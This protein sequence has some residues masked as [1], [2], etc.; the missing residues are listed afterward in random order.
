MKKRFVLSRFSKAVALGSTVLLAS[1]PLLAQVIS[2]GRTQTQIHTSGATTNVTTQSISQGHGVNSFSQFDVGQG[3]TVNLHAPQ[4]TQG[5]VNIVSGSQSQIHGMVRGMQNGQ[6]GGNVYIANPNG[7]V[8]GPSGTIRGGSV[9][10]STPSQSALNGM[11][12]STGGINGQAMQRV[13]DGSAPLGPGNITVRGQVLA[14]QHLGL[15]AGGY[16]EIDGDLVAG[17]DLYRGQIHVDGHRGVRITGNGR[18]NSRHGQGGGSVR[19][20]SGQN[21]TVARGARVLSQSSGSADAG[22]IYLFAEDSALLQPGAVISAV[23]TGD[24]AGGIVEFSARNTVEAL[25]DLEAWSAA[26]QGGEIIIDPTDLVLTSQNTLGADL[27]LIASGSI[28][29]SAGEVVTTQGGDVTLTAPR[30][31]LEQ[32]SVI[33]ASVLSGTGGNIHIEARLDDRLTDNATAPGDV[34]GNALPFGQAE[35]SI[36]GAILRGDAVFVTATVYKDNV[37]QA[38][39][40]VESL[41]NELKGTLGDY[42]PISDILELAIT[43]G[44][45]LQAALDD[46]DIENLPSYLDARTRITID[47]S[48]IVADKLVEVVASSTTHF[49]IAPDNLNLALAIAGS[50]TQADVL[51]HNSAIDAEAAISIRSEVNEQQMLQARS[52][53]QK[54][55]AEARAFN[56]ALAASLRRSRARTIV[57]GVRPLRAYDENADTSSNSLYVPWNPNVDQDEYAILTS[58]GP[59]EIASD[60]IKDLTL[61]SEALVSSDAK[62][63]ALTVSIEDSRAETRF[64]GVMAS[65]SGHVDV[66]AETVYDTY[67]TRSR[68]SG[69]SEAVTN[70]NTD[71]EDQA[72]SQEDQQGLQADSVNAALAFMSG[73]GVADTLALPGLSDG[74]DSG[75]DDEE[76]GRFAFAGTL[77]S[78]RAENIAALGGDT[79]YEAPDGTTAQFYAPWIKTVPDGSYGRHG[80]TFYADG[81]RVDLDMDP[82]VT[83]L[84]RNRFKDLRVETLAQV[85]SVPAETPEGDP[86][87]TGD[88]TGETE[89]QLDQAGDRVLM[90]TAGITHWDLSAEAT[91]DG[92][93]VV[94]H[95]AWLRVPSDVQVLSENSFAKTEGRDDVDTWWEA[96]RAALEVRESD[97]P[98]DLIE[99]PANDDTP[100]DTPADPDEE[101]GKGKFGG[102]LGGKLGGVGTGTK[103]SLT[104]EEETP[105]DPAADPTVVTP[106][107]LPS[108]TG[109]DD[110]PVPET[111][112]DADE[113]PATNPT[114]TRMFVAQSTG[115]GSEIGAGVNLLSTQIGLE[116]KTTVQNTRIEQEGYYRLNPGLGPID[117]EAKLSIIARNSGDIL[118]QS[119]L[120]GNSTGGEKGGYGGALS[121]T[122]VTARAQTQINPNTVL[123]LPTT[124]I[125]SEQDLL[126]GN[127]ARAHG[128]NDSS[129]TA[130]N[131]AVGITRYDAQTDVALDQA[132]LEG[133]EAVEI[134]ARDAS[135]VVTLAGSGAL[136]AETSLAIGVAVNLTKRDSSLALDGAELNVGDAITLLAETSGEVLAAGTASSRDERPPEPEPETDETAPDADPA[137]PPTDPAD[138]AEAEQETPITETNDGAVDIA[139]SLFGDQADAV[140]QSMG[141]G[142]DGS[143]PDTPAGGGGSGE[144]DSRTFSFA[145]DFAGTFGTVTTELLLTDSE[146]QTDLE[147][148][149][150]AIALSDIH[151]GQAGSVTASA[152]DGVGITGSFGLSL[153]DHMTQTRLTDTNIYL[154]ED[155]LAEGT[156]TEIAARDR[157]VFDVIVTGRAGHA[158]DAWGLAAAASFN[159]FDST[160]DLELLRSNITNGVIYDFGG[161]GE[162][163]DLGGD[164]PG[165]GELLDPGLGDE[166]GDP[167]DEGP[168]CIDAVC[169]ENTVGRS[170]ILEAEAAPT[171]TVTVFAAR[172]VQGAEAQ[173][174]QQMEKV[175]DQFEQA[176]LQA[177][178]PKEDDQDPAAPPSSEPADDEDRGKGRKGVS[179]AI[180][181]SVVNAKAQVSLR[182][183]YVL[184]DRSAAKLGVSDDETAGSI[185]V[186]SRAVSTANV[187]ATSGTVGL[188]FVLTDTRSQIEIDDTALIAGGNGAVTVTSTVAENQTV[189]ARVASDSRYKVAGILSLR[190]AQNHVI[191]DGDGMGGS[192]IEGGDNTAVTAQTTRALAFEA[193]ASD[194]T[195][196]TLAGAGIVS[197]GSADTAVLMGGTAETEKGEITLSALDTTT[198]YSARAI[199]TTGPLTDAE[200]DETI[201]EETA[202][203]EE[204]GTGETVKKPK[205]PFGKPAKAKTPGKDEDSGADNNGLTT[206]FA[207][208]A[209]SSQERAEGEAETPAPDA[210]DSA[211]EEKASSAPSFVIAIN[212][213]RSDLSAQAQVGGTYDDAATGDQHDLS[214]AALRGG[215]ATVS[216]GVDL[217]SYSKETATKAGSI[218]GTSLGF[219]GTVSYG[220]MQHAAKALLGQ[221]DAPLAI[222]TLDLSAQNTLPQNDLSTLETALGGMHDS[223]DALGEEDALSAQALLP[224][225]SVDLERDRWNIINRTEGEAKQSFV[226]DLGIHTANLETIAEVQDGGTLPGG[227]LNLSARNSGGLTALRDIPLDKAKAPEPTEAEDTDTPSDTPDTPADG[228]ADADAQTAGDDL[229]KEDRKQARAEAETEH[230]SFGLGAAVQYLKID[231]A[232]RAQIGQV[233]TNGDPATLA[234]LSLSAENDMQGLV[235][236]KSFGIATGSSLNGGLGLIDYRGSAQ[237]LL[238]ARV[239]YVVDGATGVTARD[240]ADLFAF[241]GAGSQAGKVSVGL[242]AGLIFADRNATALIAVD[243]LAELLQGKAP[244]VGADQEL[245]ALTLSATTAGHSTAGASAG[246]EGL[247]ASDDAADPANPDGAQTDDDPDAPKRGKIGLPSGLTAARE[248]E[249]QEGLGEQTTS[250]ETGQDEASGKSF[251]FALAADF[252]GVFG[253]NAASALLA[254][255]NDVKLDSTTIEATNQAGATLSSGAAIGTGGGVGLSGSV[256]LSLIK[257][258]VHAL[259]LGGARMLS[260]DQTVSARDSG[261]LYATAIGRGGAGGTFSLVGS[262]ALHLGHSDLNARI[263]G[264][265]IDTDGAVRVTAALSGK[266]IAIAGSAAQAVVEEAREAKLGDVDGAKAP[267]TPEEAQEALGDIGDILGPDEPIPDTPDGGG[268]P[269]DTNDPDQDSATGGNIGVGLTYTQITRRETVTARI[270]DT[271]IG[272]KELTLDASNAR[273]ITGIASA[274]GADPKIGLSVSASV[275]VLN[276]TTTAEATGDVLFNIADAVEISATNTVQAHQQVGFSGAGSV[277]ALGITGAALIDTRTTTARLDPREIRAVGGTPDIS[278]TALQGGLASVAVKSGLASNTSGDEDG[279][280]AVNIPVS[281]VT[282]NWTTRA[283]ISGVAQTVGAVSLSARA[284]AE[285]RNI[286]EAVTA[287]GQAAGAVGVAMTNYG[288]DVVAQAEGAAIIADSFDATAES[289]TVLRAIAARDGTSEVGLD[290]IT[291]ILRGTGETRAEIRDSL[292]NADAITLTAR[293]ATEHDVFANGVA[294]NGGFGASGG[295]AVDLYRRDVKALANGST[296]TA[297]SGSINLTAL[298]EIKASTIVLGHAASS[299]GLVDSSDSVA[300]LFN[301]GWT[302]FSRDVIAEIRNSEARADGSVRLHAER[303]DNLLSIQGMSN[304]AGTGLG[305]GGGVAKFDGTTAARILGDAPLIAG[306]DVI[307]TARD[308]TKTLQLAIGVTVN[309][310]FGGVGSFGYVDY[311]QRADALVQVDGDE[312]GVLLRDVAETAVNSVADGIALVTGWDIPEFSLDRTSVIEARL[313]IDQAAVTVD[314]NLELLAE[315]DRSAHVVSGQVAANLDL[316]ITNAVLDLFTVERD[317]LTGKFKIAVRPVAPESTAQPEDDADSDVDPGDSQ[318]AKGAGDNLAA[319][320]QADS[321]DS[322]NSGGGGSDASIA[323]GIGVSW[324][325]LGGVVDATLDL[326]N[327]GVTTVGVDTSVTARSE[328]T[329]MTASL[330]ASALGNAVGA[331]GAV[332]RQAQLVRARVMGD[333]TLDTDGLQVNGLSNSRFWSIAGVISVGED[334]G[335]GGTLALNETHSRTQAIVTDQAVVDADGTVSLDAREDSRSLALS[336]A[337]AASLNQTAISAANGLNFS[338]AAVDA[339][340]EGAARINSGGDLLISAK[341][342]QELAAMAYQVTIASGVGVGGALALA[343]DKGVTDARISQARAET[344]GD[345]AVRAANNSKVVSSAMGGGYSGSVGVMGSAAITLKDDQLTALIDQSSVNA[346]DSVLVQAL[347]GGRL[348][349][350]G[351][352]DETFFGSLDQVTGSI[353]IGNS[354]AIGVSVSIIE[355]TSDVLAA[356]HDSDVVADALGDGVA[357]QTRT[358][359]DDTW[360]DRTAAT[361]TGVAVVADTTTQFNTLT[362]SGAVSAG[363]SVSAQLPVV[364]VKDGV[365]AEIAQN[366]D[367]TSGAD[368]DVFAGNATRLNLISATA[369]VGSTVGVGA[370]NEAFIISKTTQARIIDAT[371]QSDRDIRVQA[372]TPEYIR[373]LSMAGAGGVWAGIGGVNQLGLTRSVTMAQVANAR[374]ISGRDVVV[375]ARA[376]RQMQQMAGSLGVGFVGVGGTILILNS[377]DQVLAETVDG[378]A[379]SDNVHITLARHLSVEAEARMIPFGSGAPILPPTGNGGVAANQAVAGFA[380]G[381]VGVAG[382]GLYTESRQTVWARLGDLTRVDGGAAR[383]VS[384][385]ALQSYGQ[386]VYVITQSG[387][388]GALGIAGVITAMRNSVL[389]EIG[390]EVDLNVGGEV[391]VEALGDRSFGGTVIAGGGGILSFQGSGILLTYGRPLT[392]E[393]DE[394]DLPSWGPA[395]AD[396]N[397]DLQDDPYSHSDPSGQDQDYVIGLGDDLIERILGDVV[398][399]RNGVDLQDSFEG[400]ARDTIVARIGSDSRIDAR[401]IDVSARETG[402]LEILAGGVSLGGIAAT[403]GVA[404]VRRGTEVRTEIGADSTLIASG[405]LSI[406]SE[407]DVDDGNPEAIAGAGGIIGSAAAVVDM[408]VGRV[409]QTDIADGVTLT[410]QGALTVAARETA[411][412]RAKVTSVQV[413]GIGAGLAVANAVRDSQIGVVLGQSVLTGLGDIQLDATRIGETRADVDLLAISA[414]GMGATYA[415]ARDRAV[416]TVVLDAAQISGRDMNIHAINAGDVL[417]DAKGNVGGGGTTGV[418]VALAKRTA[419]TGITANGAGLTG[420]DLSLLATDN[421]LSGSRSQI[422]ASSRSTN[423]SLATLAGSYTRAVNA[424]E[425]MADLSFD[426]FDFAGNTLIETRNAT[427]VEYLSKGLVAGLAGFG[428]NRA[429]G[430]DESISRLTLSFAQAATVGGTF[431]VTS[432]GRSYLFGNAISGRGG[433]V[434]VE[435]SIHELE[436]DTTTE[437]TLTG[438]AITADT[439]RVATERDVIFESNSDSI[440][441]A[442]VGAGATKQT[443]TVDSGALLRLG[444]DLTAE[445]IEIASENR[446]TKRAIDF[447]GVTGQYGG[448]NA[449]AL[450]SQTAVDSDARLEILSGTDL[451]QTGLTGDLRISM[452]SDY[453]LT[454]RLSADMGGV[455]QLPKAESLVVVGDLTNT[456]DRSTAVIDLQD[457]NLRADGNV[458]IS[459]RADAQLTSE[460]YVRTFGLAG[461]GKAISKAKLRHDGTILLGGGTI[462]SLFGNVQIHAGADDSTLQSQQVFAEARVF[463]ATAAPFAEDAQALALLYGDSVIEQASGQTIRAGGDVVIEATNGLTD[464]YAYSV[465]IDTF[466][467]LG[468]AVVNFFGGLLGADEVSY[469]DEGGEVLEAHT[470]GLRLNGQIT[471]GVNSV[472]RLSLDYAPGVSPEDVNGPEDLIITVEGDVPY[473]LQFDRVVGDAL[474][475][476]IAD[477]TALRD[478]YPVASAV[479]DTLNTQIEALQARLAFLET[480]GTAGLT[481]DFLLINGVSAQGGNVDLVGDF[482]VGTAQITAIGDAL[483]EVNNATHLSMDVAD[484]TIPF[485]NEGRIRFNG[486]EVETNAD[487]SALGAA[488]SD[489]FAGL[490]LPIFGLTASNSDVARPEILLN[491][492]Y[493]AD[494]TLPADIYVSGLV[495]NLEG[496]V[497]IFTQ[498]GSVY[499]FGGDINARAVTIDSGGDFFLAPSDPTTHLTQDPRGIYENLFAEQE[500]Y[501]N[502]VYDYA[503]ANGISFD[504]A[505][506]TFVTLLGR[507]PPAQVLPNTQAGGN[508]TALGNIF[509]YADVLNINGRIQSGITDWSL[510]VDASIDPFLNAVSWHTD[511]LEIYRPLRGS[512]VGSDA[513]SSN[514]EIVG[515]NAPTPLLGDNHMS[516]N[517]S[518]NFDPVANRL[519]IAPILTRGGY[520]EIAG[521]IASTGGGEIV[522]AHGYGRLNVDN[523]SS[524]DLVFS[525]VD[526]GPDGGVQGTIR[527]IDKTVELPSLKA[528]GD[529]PVYKTTTIQPGV[530]G[531]TVYDVTD[532]LALEFS[533]GVTS[534]VL[535]YTTN[536]ETRRFLGGGGYASGDPESQIASSFATPVADSPE[537]GLLVMAPGAPDYEFV[538]SAIIFDESSNVVPIPNAENGDWESTGLFTSRRPVSTTVHQFT[539]TRVLTHRV[540]AD[541]DIAVRATGHDA[542]A[543]DITSTGNVYF[544]ENLRVPEGRLEVNTG[545]DILT[546]SRDAT[547]TSSAIS[548]TTNGA[549]GGTT[550]SRFVTRQTLVSSDIDLPTIFGRRTGADLSA[551]AQAYENAL[552]G[553]ANS[554]VSEVMQ[555]SGDEI[556]TYV[557]AEGDVRL[558][559]TSG[560]LEI[561]VV[562]TDFLGDIQLEAAGDIRPG[563]FGGFVEGANVILSSEGGAIGVADQAGPNGVPTLHV[564]AADDLIARAFGDID[565]TARTL[566]MRVN[567]VTSQT[568]DVRLVSQQGSIQDADDF[569]IADRRAQADIL[570]ALWNELQLLDNASLRDVTKADLEQAEAALIDEMTQ[571]YF[572]WWSALVTYDDATGKPVEVRDYH[573]DLVLDVSEQEFRTLVSKQGMTEAEIATLVAERTEAFHDRAAQYLSDDFNPEFVHTLSGADKQ[574]ISDQLQL[575]KLNADP[576]I[577]RENDRLTA[578]YF[579]WWANLQKRDPATGAVQAVQD[580]DPGVNPYGYDEQARAEMRANGMSDADIDALADAQNARFHALATLYAGTA[581]DAGYRHSLDADA[582]QVLRDQAYFTTTELEAA[583]RRDL[584]LPVVDTQITVENANVS[585]Q[586]VTLEAGIDIGVA[587]DPIIKQAGDTLTRQERLAL[588]SANRS[589]VEILADRVIIRRNDDLDLAVGGALDASAGRH[590]WLGSETDVA[591]DQIVSAGNTYLRSSGSISAMAGAGQ[592]TGERVLLEASGGDLGAA[593]QPVA[594]NL[595][596]SGDLSARASGDVYLTSADTLAV[597]E[598]YTP[599]TV[600]VD[601]TQGNLIGAGQGVDILAGGL[602]ANVLRGVS[603]AYEATQANARLHVVAQDDSDLTLRGPTPVDLTQV[604]V[605]A[606]SLDLTSE[607]SLRLVP[608]AGAVPSARSGLLVAGD[609]ITLEIGGDLIVTD[610]AHNGLVANGRVTL[611]VDGDIGATNRP[612]VLAASGLSLITGGDHAV[613]QAT[614]TLTLHGITAAQGLVDLVTAGAIDIA[615][616]LRMAG[617]G[618]MIVTARDGDITA[619]PADKVDLAGEI[620]FT[621]LNGAITGSGNGAPFAFTQETPTD[622]LDFVAAGDISLDAPGALG[623]GR[624]ISET[625]DVAV[626]SGGTLRIDLLASA[627]NPD[628]QGTTVSVAAFAK[629]QT[630]GTLPDPNAQLSSLYPQ[631]AFAGGGD[632]ATDPGTD[633]GTGG[634]GG[635]PTDPGT[636]GGS[637]GDPGTGG[638][639]PTDPGTGGG[640]SGTPTDPGTGSGGGTP[641]NPGSG[642][643]P[644]FVKPADFVR[645]PLVQ[646]PAAL[647]TPNPGGFGIGPIGRM[648]RQT[649]G[650]LPGRTQVFDPGAGKKEEEEKQP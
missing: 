107:Q 100:T 123:D 451:T 52:G 335:F 268:T 405:D 206:A 59:I 515:L 157:S 155:D 70:V 368:V 528:P 644:V 390:D 370:V 295:V 613:L 483:I 46:L 485:T 274:T 163:G 1:E 213:D 608:A 340:L 239:P 220:H 228:A 166:L 180:A 316:I 55:D 481:T 477:L 315:D 262:A 643:K 361:R 478:G 403:H 511:P 69:G 203:Q 212:A 33:D 366:A 556:T 490:E 273:V 8:V 54:E 117:P 44:Q 577:Q 23:A 396:A 479:Y 178:T 381:F 495:E 646:R 551:G 584:I 352:A 576:V 442:L 492:T 409:V 354:A 135:D 245:G 636:G 423:I 458:V 308:A 285:L 570:D 12:D 297:T 353:T 64:G 638:G 425:V 93:A 302:S 623:L 421:V 416:V 597:Q 562:E 237:A 627:N 235:T 124:T 30:I 574:A 648:P 466:D 40:A 4:G 486:N 289:T 167:E 84:A 62:G 621:A 319:S 547:I 127:V 557:R 525:H 233:D 165:D 3:Q 475:D 73:E 201:E 474:V 533:K 101:E 179:I 432:T 256:S 83:V 129:G 424:S 448:I 39:A 190:E 542:A 79:T 77:S 75:S 143:A 482:A 534:H 386:D 14:D 440:A 568:G 221:L 602:Q 219:I 614:E 465:A 142:D 81:G 502:Q 148:N 566:S 592:V 42:Q 48:H 327:A 174:G 126:I 600:H 383:D 446:F 92:G 536:Y 185:A 641:T 161:G 194:S 260:G 422:F 89:T 192:L 236:T 156:V 615:G 464:P 468:E 158:E 160:A 472:R 347:N 147:N 564:D 25:G 430:I 411:A 527:L 633:G 196:L 393:D 548:F 339:H 406:V 348:D 420:D 607:G 332:T 362:L 231:A 169:S 277:F 99:A 251:G 198:Q 493:I 561:S 125:I 292:I 498:D 58:G 6:V 579:E 311:G 306:G 272:A 41:A 342:S 20:R 312:R 118:T 57:N 5:T 43:A 271:D 29:L 462:E 74:S 545:G 96:Y 119:G 647:I 172:D 544:T 601:V 538:H 555:L 609:D 599:G 437:L 408:R 573:P 402:A 214:D 314:G 450:L 377:R 345:V 346:G 9:R 318:G 266:S 51:V 467:E 616:D 459:N 67:A 133:K 518:V 635:T 530:N 529:A 642:T 275:A 61:T 378:S 357:S 106:T 590:I 104:G 598:I 49:E 569:Q 364:L 331:G 291:A 112:G 202:A 200:L 238:D 650:S 503:L 218:E 240:A 278:V 344:D 226:V 521:R 553:Q 540:R 594:I 435:G 507:V 426:Q 520:I 585:G 336:F 572:D 85:G 68:V 16:V 11:F 244:G 414:G 317:P 50:N 645:L 388:A 210:P 625:G 87:P 329:L 242:G 175:S 94:D 120:P 153:L 631:W 449:A 131:I 571:A 591:V 480:I 586:N 415:R 154:F 321:S 379:Q 453:R 234:G 91:I 559:N 10:L 60:V 144:D 304:R 505:L 145:G 187:D 604:S 322:G 510:T 191:V 209:D 199:V 532:G 150:S 186:N 531:Q 103:A 514:V 193:L 452:L 216:A 18:I 632:P 188:S 114:D 294:E 447:N 280:F 328:T 526:L 516:G 300:G 441:V 365:I 137:D 313:D 82:V 484:I 455:V 102:R 567:E 208:I 97:D 371:V 595:L 227:D 588:F 78:H 554:S 360:L 343:H 136:D 578:Q 605:T 71:E 460:A 134:T 325:R 470:T 454:D 524:R 290:V 283:D 164:A 610:P 587:V 391:V 276:Q 243:P 249:H 541:H 255:D 250:D 263:E 469:A 429:K 115:R 53:T 640:G 622:T 279:G 350:V 258:Q 146:I 264:R 13:M 128:Q 374:L 261:D 434:S 359:A 407:A 31:T 257:T 287:S 535:E 380:G 32:D 224:D 373:T 392:I 36:T 288:S 372:L 580:Y 552:L 355:S 171:S 223:L 27:T 267:S 419:R 489:L 399:D 168:F 222:G 232:S 323:L 624:V 140:A 252:A 116:T 546:T 189:G 173:G 395:I 259:D 491:S 254:L 303:L 307:L 47:D 375:H 606:G 436:I 34:Q 384:V 363:V 86:E 356:I 637:P 560:A 286:Q 382:A 109:E 309:S 282:T 204:A 413:T 247:T 439:I 358:E 619:D 301:L 513:D 296:L 217:Q 37:V 270:V 281:I 341:R 176:A 582:A 177:E 394:D 596:P 284:Q 334:L 626:T 504:A 401:S 184:A 649:R 21:L 121:L 630:L 410:A 65:E 310:S 404:L 246:A 17:S 229:T 15:Q 563:A 207:N 326:D 618:R 583:Y 105:A 110:V 517:V 299:A 387:G 620:A 611:D 428:L 603:L 509:I 628:L 444:A 629:E 389:A 211:P 385:R 230:G 581:F 170:V 398:T 324:V 497:D 197:L 113:T 549:V 438:A 427:N 330:G 195:A 473:Q 445:T 501:Y 351:G 162:D 494:E 269:P 2:D 141:D 111:P 463:N 56:L 108:N 320:P 45:D 38:D 550:P 333:G 418:N 496:R 417:A 63:V 461:K 88:L 90:I 66:R 508:V 639:S 152:V 225:P 456:A 512:P 506:S 181:P 443:N 248:Q 139:A 522:A 132:T 293:D 298:S 98:E 337:G 19:V 487:L 159:R 253:T 433:L 519:E 575:D 24:G 241:G 149:V 205:S 589:D 7:F 397:D 151:Y 523:N 612:L 72:V 338:R 431:E 488:R 412:T 26:G 499:V 476:F 28:T 539:Q 400:A 138:P 457:T 565:M 305:I 500:A 537:T 80:G 265:E 22:E 543:A 122:S 376:P 471:A 593:D 634:G 35:I 182:D 215:K 183:S 369:A 558:R 76:A 367:V 349:S 130:V 95:D 617:G